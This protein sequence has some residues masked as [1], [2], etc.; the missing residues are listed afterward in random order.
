[1]KFQKL[2]TSALG[3]IIICATLALGFQRD[4]FRSPNP[5]PNPSPNHFSGSRQAQEK[6][7]Q[8]TEVK[9]LQSRIQKL[10][11]KVELLE[12]RIEEMRR[13]R[14]IPVK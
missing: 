2:I 4:P 5:S 10:E 11:S 13:P 1:M 14:V 6:T 9:E 12:R 8:S 7:D 3:A